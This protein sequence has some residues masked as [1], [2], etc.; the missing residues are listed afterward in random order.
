[1]ENKGFFAY[2]EILNNPQRSTAKETKQVS[3]F[4]KTFDKLAFF[5]KL[6]RQKFVSETSFAV[7]SNCF[8]DSNDALHMNISSV[9]TTTY[10]YFQP[11]KYRIA[12]SESANTHNF[13]SQNLLMRMPLNLNITSLFLNFLA[14]FVLLNQIQDILCIV[15]HAER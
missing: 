9:G 7:L 14:H 11:L 12:K 10:H 6:L 8:T 3:I 2:N 4:Q 1:M 13:V 15:D 5:S